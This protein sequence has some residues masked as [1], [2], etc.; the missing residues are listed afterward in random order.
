MATLGVKGLNYVTDKTSS[1]TSN[2]VKINRLKSSN[3]H[4]EKKTAS[5]A[6]CSMS[7]FWKHKIKHDPAVQLSV[8]EQMFEPS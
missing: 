2:I 8:S 3:L 4:F 5:P 6:E 7:E 1:F